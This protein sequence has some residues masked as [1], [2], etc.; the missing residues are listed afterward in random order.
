MFMKL[1]CS[2][3]NQNTKF[4]RRESVNRKQKLKHTILAPK[5]VETKLFYS[6][7]TMLVWDR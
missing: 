7:R 5:K 6:V 2:R 4:K 3:H 1:V